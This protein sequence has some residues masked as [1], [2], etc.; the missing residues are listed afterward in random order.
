MENQ[1]GK[2]VRK[3]FIR[4]FG[5][6]L[7]TA[8]FIYIL[9]IIFVVAFTALIYSGELSSQIPRAL[10]FIIT[11][12]AMLCM[13][14]A[15]L[16]SNPAAIGVE[17]DTP[18][19][20]LSVIAVG[21][22]AALSGASSHQ[23]ATVTMMIITTTLLTSLVL[24]AL[25]VFK[26]GGLARF[27][28]YPVIGGFLAGSGWL[29][30]QGGVGIMVDGR[31]VP[32]LLEWNALML[33]IPGFVLGIMIYLTAQKIK[34]P[35][36]IPSLMLVACVLFYAWAW[37]MNISIPK[38]Q[39][40]GWLLDSSLS[41]GT[42]GFALSPAIVLQVDWGLLFKQLPAL[43]AVAI[44]SVVALLL[45]SSGM[46]LILKKDIDLNREL[47]TAGIGNL[48]AGLAGGL[49]GFQDIS[50]STLN[51]VMGGGRRLVGLLA[52]LLIGA[53]I[54]VGTS[55]ILYIPK[56]VLGSV[57]IYLGIELLV[58]WVYQ[59]WFKFSRLDFFVVMTILVVLAAWGVLEG[60]IAGLILAVFTFVVSYSRISVIKFAFTGREYNSRVT[61]APD[62]QQVL[63]THG[64]ELYIMRLEGFIFFGTANGIFERLREHV[65]SATVNKIK[66][67]L[68]DFSKV[69]GIDST[70]ML[71]FARMLQWSQEQGITLIIAGLAEEMQKQ[72]SP[73]NL[74]IEGRALKLFVDADH[75]IEWCENEIMAANLVDL[76]VNRDL[77]EQLE[78]IL[79]DNGGE[80]L[81]PYLNCHEYRTGEYLIREGDVA[82]FIYF[83][84][85]GHVT[86]QLESTGKNP[87]RLETINSGRTVGEIAF[88]LGTRRTA[89]V[90]ANQDS[91]VYSLSL[92][93][94]E[95][96]EV[97]DPES[98]NLFHRLSVILLS[99][100]VMHLT[101]TVRA[102]ERS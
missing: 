95:R 2:I 63:E 98:A 34:K 40:Q 22:I 32:R 47:I 50:F 4:T 21:I 5:T 100:R 67:S 58:E 65:N 74:S 61:R 102:L 56:F 86:A 17:Q 90:I 18:G 46:E 25:G 62:E 53:T 30:V 73:A 101:Y 88:F 80:R 69:T 72:F 8:F 16:S 42:W 59:A 35:Y 26:L 9:E 89:S 81:I 82:D 97:S 70:G 7:F 94:L 13:V 60:V 37:V 38:L 41:T 49:V 75:G 51:H 20:M 39:A 19:V 96:M 33:W 76:H 29:L 48:A 91:I 6:S 24:S 84:Q 71:S 79:G 52:A 14:V 36:T 85:S 92:E 57:L 44:I 43:I 23:F 66:Y 28:P 3:S 27:L 54:F 64:D 87:I 83:I 31:L 68:F 93:D 10:G 99:Q 45:N 15:L 55:A 78:A 11:G 1:T 12:D 77:S